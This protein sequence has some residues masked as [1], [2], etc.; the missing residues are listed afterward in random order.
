MPACHL[1]GGGRGGRELAAGQGLDHREQG[2]G[3][4]V[5]G[6]APSLHKE[7]VHIYLVVSKGDICARR[8]ALVGQETGPDLCGGQ[9]QG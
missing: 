4:G 2:V 1:R 3:G 9:G 6:Q 8:N 5:L 7:G